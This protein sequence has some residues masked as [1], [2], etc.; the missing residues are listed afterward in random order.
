MIE[1]LEL[2]A[3]GPEELDE[4]VAFC[5]TSELE[6]LVVV[7]LATPADPRHPLSQFG[8]SSAD[9]GRAV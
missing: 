6:V 4:I 5:R 2:I 9:R 7:V 1:P 8:S 3:T